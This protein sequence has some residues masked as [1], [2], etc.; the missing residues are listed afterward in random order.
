M[1]KL[2]CGVREIEMINNFYP[3]PMAR[4]RYLEKGNRSVTITLSPITTQWETRE[5]CSSHIFARWRDGAHG[6][7]VFTF[8]AQRGRR[9]VKEF[10]LYK[11]FN[12]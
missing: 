7:H 4:R 8:S 1:G 6:P 12:K 5:M 2:S 10:T 3:V 9:F 11:E